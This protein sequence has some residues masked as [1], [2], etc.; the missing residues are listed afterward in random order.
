MPAFQVTTETTIEDIIDRYPHTVAVLDQFG[1][2]FDPF[3]YI[4]LKSS[5]EDAAAYNA[6]TDEER[7]RFLAALQQAIESPDGHAA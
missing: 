3:T 7:D 4:T 2:Y 5:I 1:V 6:L